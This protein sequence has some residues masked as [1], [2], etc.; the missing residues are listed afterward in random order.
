MPRLTIADSEIEIALRPGETILGGLRR[1]GYA[2]RTGCLRGGCGICKVEISSGSVTYQETVADT[3]LTPQERA[4]AICLICRAIPV[5]DVQIRV[6]A[7]F[8]LRCVSPLL[9]NLARE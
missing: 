3:V 7:D 4:A 1:A 2:A 6:K 5:E 9:A 8:N